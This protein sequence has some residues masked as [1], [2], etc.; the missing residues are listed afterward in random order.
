MKIVPIRNEAT[1]QQTL[2]RIDQL[3]D[4]TPGTPRFDELEVLSVL[5][6][7]YEAEHEPIPPPTALAAIAF[8]MERKGL[9]SK[10]L[11]PAIGQRNRV[12]EVLNGKRRLTLEMIRKLGP[13]LNLPADVLIQADPKTRS[14]Y[15]KRATRAARER[16][17]QTMEIHAQ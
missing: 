17:P 3:M 2:H 9:G 16:P 5:I 7:S 14:K 13:L 6:H 4:A 1:Y 10:D 15:R 12:S 8:A 11:I